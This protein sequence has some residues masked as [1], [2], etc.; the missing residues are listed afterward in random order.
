MKEISFENFIKD[1]EKHFS[2]WDFS[3]ITD[4]GRLNKG[5]L[6]W[7]YGSIVLPYI[8]K[9]KAMLD[10]GTGGGELLSKFQPL[11]TFTC[12]TEGYAPNFPVAKNRLDPLGVMVRKVKNDNLLPFE[13]ETFDLIINKHEE[14]LPSEVK[15]VMALKGSFITQQVGGNDCIEINHALGAPVN[16]EFLHW[17]LE[18]ARNELVQEGFDVVEW[19]EEEPYQRFYDIGALVYYLKAIPWQVPDFTIERYKDSLFSIHEM[20]QSKGFFE[21]KTNR[22]LLKANVKMK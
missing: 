1:I 12:A 22:F 2:G 20:I 5:M 13:D 9:S 14:Y 4:S 16:G 18:Y 21:V 19:M 10:M 17:N 8:R 11:P 7:S 3:Y 15:R 6:S